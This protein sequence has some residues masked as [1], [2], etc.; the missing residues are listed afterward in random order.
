MPEVHIDFAFL[1]QMSV[2]VDAVYTY[3]NNNK[4]C[5]LLAAVD[6]SGFDGVALRQ[7]RSLRGTNILFAGGDADGFGDPYNRTTFS[8]RSQVESLSS[9]YS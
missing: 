5:S 3:M 9:K 4:L 7:S 2:L 8:V 6:G 1:S